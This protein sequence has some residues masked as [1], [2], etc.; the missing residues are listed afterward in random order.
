MSIVT[1]DDVVSNHYARYAPILNQPFGD[2]N[3]IGIV[4][5]HEGANAPNAIFTVTS[6]DTKEHHVR[7]HD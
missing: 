2:A 3:V 6:L 7:L 4:N 1:T 5:W